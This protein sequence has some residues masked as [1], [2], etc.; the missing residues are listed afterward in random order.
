[1]T[2]EQLLRHSQIIGVGVSD[3]FIYE[4][5]QSDVEDDVMNLL[6]LIYTY[7]EDGTISGDLARY[8]SD[9]TSP[10][11]REYIRQNILRNVESQDSY[12]NVPDEMISELTRDERETSYAY[13]SR[14]RDYLDNASADYKSVKEKLDSEKK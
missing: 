9:N 11:I 6:R 14:V 7:N 2:R 1:M 8:L 13:A 4:G 3:N 5:E 10:E 12:T